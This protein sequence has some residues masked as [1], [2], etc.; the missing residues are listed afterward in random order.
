MLA[1]RISTAI[2][3]GFKI[4][5]APTIAAR[6]AGTSQIV[7][8]HFKNDTPQPGFST[9]S[10]REEAFVF[11]IPL[12]AAR[13]SRVCINGNGQ[14]VVQSPG[15]AYLFDLTARTEVSLDTAYEAV[16]VHLPQTAIDDLA[17]ERGLRRVGGLHA[18]ALGQDDEILH[19]LAQAMLPAI[20]NAQQVTTAFVEY[21]A[22][23]F[24]AHVIYQY[25]G[26]PRGASAKGGLAPWQ[27]RRSCDL[28]E[29]NLAGDPSIAMLSAECGLSASHFVRA[30]RASLGLTPHQWI[31]KRRV[32]RART[33]LAQTGTSLADIALICGFADQ[34]HLGR[35]FLREAGVRPA[36]WRRRRR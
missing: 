8:S 4:P 35:V 18:R 22:L 10:A 36:E 21:L 23:A 12:I 25:G 13:F 30:F 9:P 33:L 29:A 17:Y 16:R 32:E 28:I 24:H 15:K 7:F 6:V 31:L 5:P 20:A 3:K 26:V 2:G 1:D 19:R 14:S 34:S 27:I 11:N